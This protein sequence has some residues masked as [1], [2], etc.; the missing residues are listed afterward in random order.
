MGLKKRFQ[1]AEEGIQEKAGKASGEEYTNDTPTDGSGLADDIARIVSDLK[2]ISKE[3][4]KNSD[5][6]KDVALKNADRF[7][8]LYYHLSEVEHNMI[9]DTYYMHKFEKSFITNAFGELKKDEDFKKRF[10]RLIKGLDRESIDVLVTMFN[11]LEKVYWAP[12]DVHLDIYTREEKLKLRELKEKFTDK[13][14]QISG[15]LYYYSGYYLPVNGFEDSVFY[16]RHG[17]GELKDPGKI[18]NRDIIDAGGYIGDSVLIL[19][20]LTNGTVYSFEAVRKNFE[21]MQKTIELNSV[22]NA[23]LVNKALGDK[24]GRVKITV[25]GS[26]STV[27]NCAGIKSEETE[28]ADCITLDEFVSQNNAEI[29]LIKADIEGAEQ[30]FLRGA[31]KTIKEQKPTLLI[32]IYHNL[33]DLLDIKPMIEDWNLGYSFRIYRPVIRKVIAETLLIAE[34]Q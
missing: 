30:S 25:A 23:V 14:M 32:S 10:L 4:E 17:I 22:E 7:G 26:S 34:A 15:G 11:R 29:G 13:I 20:P 1:K 16:Y 31:E 24:K 3:I 33:D 28:T 19:S 12:E 18:K 21:L 5:G 27:G 6:L 9:H 8:K 2:A